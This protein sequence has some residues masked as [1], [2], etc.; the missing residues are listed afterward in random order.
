VW[1]FALKGRKRKAQGAA[2]GRND[3]QTIL[4]KSPEMATQAKAFA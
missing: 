1:F 2:L 4:I 3:Q